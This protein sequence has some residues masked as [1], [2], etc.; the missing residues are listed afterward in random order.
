MIAK[1]GLLFSFLAV[2]AIWLTTT[3]CHNESLDYDNGNQ[4]VL[5]HGCLFLRATGRKTEGKRDREH[6]LETTTALPFWADIH[7]RFIVIMA[8]HLCAQQH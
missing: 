2:L 7:A 6:A 5:K 1:P 4:Q 3:V 8:E